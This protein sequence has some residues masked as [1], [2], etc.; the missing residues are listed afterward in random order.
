MDTAYALQPLHAVAMAGRIAAPLRIAANDSDGAAA[1]YAGALPLLQA[2]LE[3]VSFGVA[4]VDADFG[5][6]FANRAA[7]RE[8]AGH[9]VLRIDSGRLVLRPS[10][11]QDELLRAL[12][13]ARSGRWSMVQ[14]DG[15]SGERTAVAVLPLSR[16]QSGADAPVLLMFGVRSPAKALAIE[17]YAQ[18]CRLTAAETRVLRALAEGLTSSAIASRHAVALTTVRTQLKS[19][20]DRTGARSITE[21]VRALGSLPPIHARGAERSAN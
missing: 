17:F 4:V 11:Y 13:G 12:A 19:I 9:P 15:D 8:C 2:V 6:P 3:H 1:L 7:L 10:R 5:V 18:S 14:L 16:H 20:R 21:L